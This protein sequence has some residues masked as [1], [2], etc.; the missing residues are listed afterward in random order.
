[1][2]SCS[3]TAARL[4]GLSPFSALEFPLVRNVRS[5]PRGVE[6]GI[7]QSQV[8]A[9]VPKSHQWFNFGGTMHRT[10]DE[11]DVKAG[12]LAV[13]N[14][15]G[16]RLIE[17]ARDKDAFVRL[18]GVESLKN[19]VTESQRVQEEDVIRGRGTNEALRK[20]VVANSQSV[21]QAQE[22]LQSAGGKAEQE[23]GAEDNRERLNDLYRGQVNLNGGVLTLNGNSFSGAT[24]V[25]GGNVTLS[26]SGTLTGAT[27]VN[28]DFTAGPSSIDFNGNWIARNNFSNNGTVA[29]QAAQPNVSVGGSTLPSAFYQRDDVQY[30][31]PGGGGQ[32]GGGLVKSGAGTL[33]ITGANTYSGGT[34][35]SG[36]TLQLGNGGNAYNG[37]TTLNSGG[38][39]QFGNGSLANGRIILGNE[40]TFGGLLTTGNASSTYSG[41]IV[42]NAGTLA[43]PS[44]PQPPMGNSAGSIPQGYGST[45]PANPTAQGFVSNQPAPSQQALGRRGGTRDDQQQELTEYQQK[46][47]A[48]NNP[49]QPASRAGETKGANVQVAIGERN[50]LRTK[51]LDTSDNLQTLINE[52]EKLARQDA[53]VAARTATPKQAVATGKATEAGGSMAVTTPAAAPAGLASLDFELPTDA[54]LYDLYRFTTPRGEARLTARAVSNST[55][56]RLAWLATVLAAAVLICAALWLVGR[57]GLDW[58][59]HPLGATLLAFAG[60][61]SL[62]SGVLP[63]LGLLAVVTGVGLLVAYLWRRR[64]AAVYATRG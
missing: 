18:R 10:E 3:S 38:V 60:L 24:S 41:T 63:L 33:T 27:G 7:E 49:S 14:K 61:V 26:G 8:R 30:F 43:L 5:Y 16:Q 39:L 36:G 64:A 52:K 21:A 19:W 42:T 9:Y 57:G 59:R 56:A 28:V 17:A 11:A 1:M 51:L 37:T 23:K 25:V 12:K 15:E 4:R 31:P 13:L 44:Q 50:N 35:I 45:Q 46:L 20:Q 34:V 55:L 58:F 6:I 29:Q 48:G 53:E 2:P 54:N 22:V 47:A 62:C 40:L 32:G